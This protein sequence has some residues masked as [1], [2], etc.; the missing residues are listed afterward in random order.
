MELFNNGTSKAFYRNGSA[1]IFTSAGFQSWIV[2]P[3]EIYVMKISETTDV[4]STIITQTYSNGT[5]RQVLPESS[6][7]DDL[8]RNVGFDFIDSYPN[9]TQQI[10]YRNGSIALYNSSGF[11]RWVKAPT[12]FFVSWEKVSTAD[13]DQYTFS[14]GTVRMVARALR[15]DDTELFKRTSFEQFDQLSNGTT[16]VTYRNGTVAVFSAT[17]FQY[18]IIPPTQFFYFYN[19]GSYRFQNLNDSVI[20][21]FNKALTV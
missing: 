3:E 16:I 8:T 12:S 9:G 1:A 10:F 7:Q 20:Y 19:D 17:G 4:S 21:H 11:D 14:N 2:R 15:T 5:V 6:A 18:Y 13:G